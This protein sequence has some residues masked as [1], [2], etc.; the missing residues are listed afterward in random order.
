MMKKVLLFMIFCLVSALGHS[1]VVSDAA[2]KAYIDTYIVPAGELTASEHNVFATNIINSKINRDSLLF[3]KSGDTLFIRYYTYRDTVLMG[4]GGA[5]TD[6][7]FLADVRDSV[8]AVLDD[9]VTVSG[10][11]TTTGKIIATSAKYWIGMD[12]LAINTTDLFFIGYT[13]YSLALDTIAF[14]MQRRAGSPDVTVKIYYGSD[15]NSAGTAIVTAGNQ[16]TTYAGQTKIA[17]FNNGTIPGGS[18]IW[19]Q[20]SAVAVK[21]KAI[22]LTLIGK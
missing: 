7:V 22:F 16:I 9:D 17:T 1:Q 21:P 18:A 4:G 15:M 5:E 11:L 10:D 20:F 3:S 19:A 8:Q 6:P 2:L 13:P 14:T 12:S